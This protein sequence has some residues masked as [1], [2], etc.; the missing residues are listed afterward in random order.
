VKPYPKDKEYRRFKVSAQITAKLKAHAAERGLDRDDLLF[1]APEE[2]GLR[3]RV[4]SATDPRTQTL[5]T[6]KRS[7][8]RL[9]ASR[10]ARTSSIVTARRGASTFAWYLRCH[11]KVGG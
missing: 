10:C 8:S 4:P 7:P 5:R 11:L 1:Q 9:I 6:P 2:E 3:E